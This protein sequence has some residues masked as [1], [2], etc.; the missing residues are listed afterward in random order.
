MSN[1]VLKQRIREVL[2][3]GYFQSPD[4]LVDVSDGPADDIHIVIVSRK[5][6]GHRWKDRDDLL[7][8]E[9]SRSLPDEELGHISL[10]VATSPEEVKTIPP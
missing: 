1:A 6:D 3:G 10:V 7:W 4:D 9:L 5:F 8:S 2:K